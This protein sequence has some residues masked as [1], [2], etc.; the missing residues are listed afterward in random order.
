MVAG[1]SLP[2]TGHLMSILGIASGVVI[3]A[4]AARFLS[5]TFRLF[6]FDLGMAICFLLPPVFLGKTGDCL[7]GWLSVL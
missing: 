7:W 4:R 5:S 2:A 6:D 3:T 1:L